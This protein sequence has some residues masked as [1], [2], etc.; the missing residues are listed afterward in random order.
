MTAVTVSF[1]CPEVV[2]NWV[3]RWSLAGA[4]CLVSDN[5]NSIPADVHG[6]AKVL[7]FSGNIGFGGGIN[8]GVLASETPIVL[9]TNP[10]TLPKSADSL[11]MLRQFHSSGTL[12][13]AGTF[14]SS[15]K[16]VHSTGIWPDLSWV[17]SQ[18]FRSAEPLWRP[19]R[20]DWLQ[21]SLIMVHRD[22]FLKAGGFSDRF[23][24]YFE[25]VDLCARAKKK[26]MEI[27]YCEKCSFIHDEGSG[28]AKVTATRLSCF[29]WGMLQ[30]FRNHDPRNAEA[31]RKMIIAKCLLRSFA[32][33]PVNHEAARGYSRALR[34]VLSGIAPKLPEV[35]NG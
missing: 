33:A 16:A 27:R 22:E 26:G 4:S 14:D 32:H 21:G 1:G 13:G 8:R 31:A 12:S 29:H 5:G 24:L 7:P 25:D 20:F 6:K 9:I 10:D 30:Y 23:P 19:D 35:S 34:S 11:E 17:R 2:R 15:G 18:I 28:S 3:E